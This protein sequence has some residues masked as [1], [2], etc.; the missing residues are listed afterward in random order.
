MSLESE[1]QELENKT[2]RKKYTYKD[3]L[4]L[5]IKDPKGITILVMAIYF[6]FEYWN[7]I[8]YRLGIN[9]HNR[10]A[11]IQIEQPVEDKDIRKS[12]YE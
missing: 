10:G 4:F 2:P 3:Y 12:N 9:I 6:L 8:A 5:I 7:F 1:K 11:K